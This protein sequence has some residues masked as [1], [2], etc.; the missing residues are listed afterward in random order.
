MTESHKIE[1][2][3]EFVEKRKPKPLVCDLGFWL[4]VVNHPAMREIN[5]FIGQI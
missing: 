4:G 2:I 5:A 1:R 3:S